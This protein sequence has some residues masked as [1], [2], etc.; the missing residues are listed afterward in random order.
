MGGTVSEQFRN[1]GTLCS[2]FLPFF[3]N[4]CLFKTSNFFSAFQFFPALPG[5]LC[6]TFCRPSTSDTPAPSCSSLTALPRFGRAVSSFFDLPLFDFSGA[7]RGNPGRGC[8]CRKP[9][10]RV[11]DQLPPQ[12]GPVMAPEPVPLP[13]VSAMKRRRR[14][15]SAACGFL[16][17]LISVERTSSRLRRACRAEAAEAGQ[18]RTCSRSRTGS[19]FPAELRP[20]DPGSFLPCKKMW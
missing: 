5:T 20:P 2:D 4:F 14:R 17:Y 7:G 11:P 18:P 6:S 10:R 13:E 16:V 1:S 15:Q 9:P 12:P 8:R 19:R 3:A